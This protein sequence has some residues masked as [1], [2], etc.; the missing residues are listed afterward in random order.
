MNLPSIQVANWDRARLAR[1]WR[2][3]RP[4]PHLLFDPFVSEAAFTGLRKAARDEPLLVQADEL[5]QFQGS[6]EP[7]ANETLR[8]FAEELGSS[9]VREAL[10]EITGLA[11]SAVS[12][13]VYR[14]GPGDYLLPHT[15]HRASQAEVNG[16]E[17][18]RLAF[19]FYLGDQPRGGALQLYDCAL[20]DN[21]L[22]RT[23]PAKRIAARPNRFAIFGVGPTSLHRV[24]ELL[25]GERLSLAGWFLA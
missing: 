5:Y 3:A 24:C 15:D 4:F 14:Y 17:E 25:E 23:R 22:V 13:R 8:A 21:A 20:D 12:L 10:R 7:P 18:R 2:A 16:E 9:A 6:A 1:Q 11:T 19:A